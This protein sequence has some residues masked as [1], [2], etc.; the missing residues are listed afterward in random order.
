M[1]IIDKPMKSGT[2]VKLK[3]DVVA[4]FGNQK[5]KKW[6]ENRIDEI[7]TLKEVSTFGKYRRVW[8]LEE[9]IADNVEWMF[10]ELDLI[11]MEGE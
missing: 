9:C 7:F 1:K 3:P 2:K 5:M 4:R 8:T 6:C 10:S 11:E